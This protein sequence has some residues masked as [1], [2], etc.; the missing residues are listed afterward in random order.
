METAEDKY[1]ITMLET[2]APAAVNVSVVGAPTESTPYLGPKNP[3]K[4][5]RKA[6][7]TVKLAVND[8]EST[9]QSDVEM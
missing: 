5:E 3:L 7:A 9:D 4:E 2:S 8:D 1:P 6:P